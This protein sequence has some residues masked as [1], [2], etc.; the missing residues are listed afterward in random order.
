MKRFK[1]LLIAGILG[2]LM[3]SLTGCGYNIPADMVAVHITSGPWQS[4]KVVGCVDSSQRKWWTNDTYALFPTSER[5]WDATGQTG[6]DSKAFTSVTKDKVI[7]NIPV[8]VRFTLITDCPTLE[9]F[10]TKYA[11][12][13]GAKFSSDGTYNDAWE[14]LLRKL[15]ADPSDQTLDRIVQGYNWQD[16]WNNPKTK[17]A[18]EQQM[19]TALQSDTSLMAQTA[20]GVYFDGISVLIG[21]PAP[22][23][24]ALSEAV[25]SEQTKVAQADADRAQARADQAK[26]VAETKVAKAEAFKQQAEILGYRLPGMSSKDALRAYNEAQLIAQGGNPYQPT[27]LVGGTIGG[28]TLPTAP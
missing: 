13:Y 18:I 26:A 12:R 1:S 16:V 6:S 10:Y 22:E 5:E 3:V 4:K 11:R 9:A 19:N 28:S 14:T 15:V 24:P 8:T 2:L 7:M 20:K 25:A 23:N 17:I 21:T 27:Y